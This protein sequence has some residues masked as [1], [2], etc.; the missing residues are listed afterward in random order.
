[1]G[2]SGAAG[3]LA[4]GELGDDLQGGSWTEDG[5]RAESTYEANWRSYR[6]AEPRV[7]H[8]V[9][10]CGFGTFLPPYWLEVDDFFVYDALSAALDASAATVAAS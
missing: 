9:L 3:P 6:L 10:V 4:Y 5:E 2:A 1:M 8:E 7:V